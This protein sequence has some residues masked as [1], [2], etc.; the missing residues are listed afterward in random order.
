MGAYGVGG[1]VVTGEGS[2]VVAR[3]ALGVGGAVVTGT[4][5]ASTDDP[6]L[7]PEIPDLEP[8]GEMEPPEA[9]WPDWLPDETDEED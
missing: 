2:A 6:Y 1:A 3:T 8:G 9:P 5:T 7:D 4:G